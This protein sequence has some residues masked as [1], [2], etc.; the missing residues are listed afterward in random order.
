[1]IA[2]YRQRTQFT[3]QPIGEAVGSDGAR[4][5][6]QTGGLKFRTPSVNIVDAGTGAV[7]QSFGSTGVAAPTYSA[8]GSALY[9]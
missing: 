5:A 8:D 9:A 2:P 6:V 3:D 7:A 4:V 1:M